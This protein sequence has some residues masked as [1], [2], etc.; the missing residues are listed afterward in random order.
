MSQRNMSI[1]AATSASTHADAATAVR[2]AWARSI[3]KSP[4][5]SLTIVASTVAHDLG[6][7]HSARLLLSHP[8]RAMPDGSLRSFTDVNVGE[9]LVCMSGNAR[10]I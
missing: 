5:P 8:E 6:T 9:Q 3:Q 2:D 7:V 10:S 1:V 4:A